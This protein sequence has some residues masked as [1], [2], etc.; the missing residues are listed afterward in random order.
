MQ[1]ILRTKVV[2][3]KSVESYYIWLKFRKTLG[4]LADQIE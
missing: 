3:L 2:E 1:E 4:Y